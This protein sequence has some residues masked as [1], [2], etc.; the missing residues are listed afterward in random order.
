MRTT[1]AID[2]KLLE[3]AKKYSGEKT[4]TATVKRALE[5]FV[6][7]KKLE[8]LLALEGKIHI[9]LDWQKMEEEEIKFQKE[10]EKLWYGRRRHRRMG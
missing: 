4:K 6:R 3:E 7:R 9:D 1:L 2:E 5:E 10:H 8:G